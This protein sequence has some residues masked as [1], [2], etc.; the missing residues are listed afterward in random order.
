MRADLFRFD[1]YAQEGEAFHIVDKTL[2]PEPPVRAHRHD[3]YE[4]FLVVSGALSHRT[5]EG[6]D[7][8][9][10]GDLTMIRPDDAHALWSEG[11]Q[12][13][14]IVNVMFHAR[15]AEHMLARYGD[16]LAGRF[17]WHAGEAALR[18]PLADGLRETVMRQ[19]Q[20][21][22]A[23][24][25]SL[26]RIE[27]FLLALT[28]DLLDAQTEPSGLPG[29]LAGAC[30]AARAPEVFR[31]GGAG[32]VAVAGRGHEH[33]CRQVRRHLGMTPTQYV[34]RIRIEHAAMLLGTSDATLAQIAEE[35]GFE[36]QGHFHRLF[37]AHYGA[38][39]G[40]FR[41]QAGDP[42]QSGGAEA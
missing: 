32:L 34:N 27:R 37:R 14:R 31:R 1:D 30:R 12:G 17:F 15:T 9:V 35:C 4:L 26:S 41:R 22:R 24:P 13:V 7:R 20:R 16:D 5:R 11:A 40:S 29:W 18:I 42:I 39:P 3:Y 2:G 8:L 25:R 10:A 36:G 33:V 28:T 19:M 23:G 6:R 38:T 21:L